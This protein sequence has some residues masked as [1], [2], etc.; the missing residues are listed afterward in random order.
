M[1][2]NKEQ[3][4]ERIDNILMSSQLSLGVAWLLLECVFVN[5]DRICIVKENYIRRFLIG[6]FYQMLSEKRTTYIEELRDYSKTADEHHLIQM[7]IQK[8]NELG[9][10]LQKKE[11]HDD[12]IY[13]MLIL[14]TTNNPIYFYQ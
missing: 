3:I 9:L 2:L 7:K 5:C 12:I 13:L 14:N 8:I 1:E 11:Y 6:D 10:L 4:L